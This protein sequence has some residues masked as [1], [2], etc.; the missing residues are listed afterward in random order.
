MGT[1]S[2]STITGLGNDRCGSADQRGEPMVLRFFCK[3]C[4]EVERS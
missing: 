4:H 2:W 3:Y 1:G